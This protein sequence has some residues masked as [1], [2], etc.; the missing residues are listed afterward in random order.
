[1]NELNAPTGLQVKHNGSNSSLTLTWNSVSGA[2]S[3]NVYE[4][5]GS[6]A[7]PYWVKIANVTGTTWTHTGL[8]AAEGHFYIVCAVDNGG[9]EGKVS[10]WA[11]G[12]TNLSIK[13]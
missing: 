5:V 4:N 7:A 3:Y 2:A 11:T 13:K 9:Y 8:K 12:M 6:T 10:G 1:L